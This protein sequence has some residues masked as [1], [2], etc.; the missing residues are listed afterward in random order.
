M[1][2]NFNVEYAYKK[3]ILDSKTPVLTPATRKQL[4]IKEKNCHAKTKVK[5]KVLSKR[6]GNLK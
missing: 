4:V 1:I 5:S 3:M 6:R 2:R